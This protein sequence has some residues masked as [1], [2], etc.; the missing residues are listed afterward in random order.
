MEDGPEG[1]LSGD[2]RGRPMFLKSLKIRDLR[3]L[4][5]VDLEFST[6]D[7][8]REIRKWSLLVG[9]N[10]TGKST[11]LKSI[12]LVLAGSECIPFLLGQPKAWVRQGAHRAVIGATLRTAAGETREVELVIRAD[13]EPSDTYKRNSETLSR[14]DDAVRH[15]Q[16]NY[17][18]VGYGPYRRVGDTGSMIQE[19]SLRPQRAQSVQ[20]LFDRNAVV[21]PLSSWAISLHYERGD[22]G[23]EIVREALDAL[24][25]GVSFNTIDR[26][27]RT[28]LFRTADGTFPLE[29][30]SDGYQN[31]AVWIGD[32]LYRVT[33]AFAH[34]KRP[35]EARGLLLIDEVDAH[36]HPAWQRRLREFLNNK[37]P[38]FQIV[39]TTHSALTL[40]QAHEGDATVLSRN[41]DGEV[42][43]ADFPGD[44]SKLRLHQLYDL[45]FRITSLDSWEIEQA[46]D[47]YRALAN[48][49][50]EDMAADERVEFA[51][52]KQ[53]LEQ[54]PTSR[55]DALG[56]PVLQ[57]F[58]RKM[59]DVTAALGRSVQR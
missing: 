9:E 36:L 46:K 55:D 16:Q 8:E 41:S 59:D 21:N 39:A 45:A 29:D 14:L 11:I 42:R 23:L 54:L 20:T 28:L 6:L 58:F 1:S 15:A 38:N 12:A 30:L 25:P 35:L 7:D 4:P 47:V 13:D 57:E 22:E 27:T 56:N 32:L 24:L 5:S 43:A 48:R 52:A 40:Q 3:S 34:F 18:V 51:I 53:T 50:E 19:S 33:S 49:P 2:R 31:I 26:K 44:P 37:L 17:F 10:G